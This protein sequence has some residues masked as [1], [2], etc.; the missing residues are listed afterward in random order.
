V[1][2]IPSSLP[3][4]NTE[5]SISKRGRSNIEG[6]AKVLGGIP[7]MTGKEN[8]IG[9]LEK[10]STSKETASRLQ[11]VTVGGKRKTPPKPKSKP[12]KKKTKAAPKKSKTPNATRLPASEEEVGGRSGRGGAVA[13][14]NIF[15]KLHGTGLESLIPMSDHDIASYIKPGE[16]LENVTCNGKCGLEVAELFSSKVLGFYCKEGFK[17]NNQGE[18]ENV[19]HRWLCI[20]CKIDMEE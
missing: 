12:S 13:A 5:N 6:A 2:D 3:V 9:R 11:H 7:P 14:K 16:Y 10:N 15:C 18:V 1:V 20:K 4:G 19:C 17:A 8:A